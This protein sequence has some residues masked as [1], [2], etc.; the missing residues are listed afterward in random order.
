MD[1]EE[2]EYIGEKEMIGIIPNFNYEPIHL[3]AGSVGKLVNLIL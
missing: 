2:L 1:P 3:I